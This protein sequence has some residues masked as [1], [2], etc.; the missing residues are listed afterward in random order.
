MEFNS[1]F[2][3]ESYSCDC[4]IMGFTYLAYCPICN[5]LPYKPLNKGIL[6]EIGPVLARENS[7]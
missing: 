2:L 7:I 4:K 1:P 6:E 5:Y 3:T